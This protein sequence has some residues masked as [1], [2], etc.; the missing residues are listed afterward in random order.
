MTGLFWR[1]VAAIA[2][3]IVRILSWFQRPDRDRQMFW[4]HGPDGNPMWYRRDD[5]KG[6]K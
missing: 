5:D 4:R 6:E 1:L 3:G 2:G